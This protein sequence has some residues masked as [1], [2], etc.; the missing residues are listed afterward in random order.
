[1]WPFH[2]RHHWELAV[3]IRSA[4]HKMLLQNAVPMTRKL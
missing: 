4:Y 1:L 3:D 2:C